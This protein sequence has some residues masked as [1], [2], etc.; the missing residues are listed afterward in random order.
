[1]DRVVAGVVAIKAVGAP[2]NSDLEQVLVDVLVLQIQVSLVEWNVQLLIRGVV[3]EILG[4]HRADV[5]LGTQRVLTHLDHKV[6]VLPPRAAPRV[7]EEPHRRSVVVPVA[8]VCD[9][10]VGAR[11]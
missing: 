5:H 6:A 4:Q 11:G 10:V 7:E 8:G 9:L 3:A 2:A 1:M